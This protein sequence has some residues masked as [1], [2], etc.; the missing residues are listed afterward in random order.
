M[1]FPSLSPAQVRATSFPRK[2]GGKGYD[3]AQV[4]AFLLKIADALAGRT[5]MHPD[6]VRRVVFHEMPGGYDQRTVDDFLAHL[7]RQLRAGAVPPTTLRTGDDLRA[8]KLRRA[9]NGYDPREVDTFLTRAAASLDGKGR[10][11]SSEVRHTRFSTTSGLR[12]GYQTRAV[13]A[14]LD[15]LEQEFRSRGR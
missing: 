12:R 13:D 11:T 2:R 1:P 3:P 9:S 10:M 4:D 5:R 6:E 8:V 15:E 7:E 14:L